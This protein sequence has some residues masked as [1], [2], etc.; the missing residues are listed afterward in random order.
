MTIRSLLFLYRRLTVFWHICPL[1]GRTCRDGTCWPHSLTVM[2]TEPFADEGIFSEIH[3]QYEYQHIIMAISV[4]KVMLTFTRSIENSPA[5]MTTQQS[6]LKWRTKCNI[7]SS[8]PPV[9]PIIP[10][11]PAA[12]CLICQLRT[13]AARTVHTG[14]RYTAEH[15]LQC[16]LSCATRRAWASFSLG[17]WASSCLCCDLDPDP[18]WQAI[19]PSFRLTIAFP[20][21]SS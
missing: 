10:K 8:Y 11:R 13:V 15:T 14:P 1:V 16:P 3:S 2:T 9:N 17:R 19:H 18:K 4:R 7:S 6:C 21:Y 5:L 12:R 20:M